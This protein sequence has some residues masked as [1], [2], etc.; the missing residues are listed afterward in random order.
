MPLY[1]FMTDDGQIV[2]QYMPAG[3]APD[4]GAVVTVTM[5]DKSIRLATRILSMPLVMGD[6]WKPYVSHR[7]PRNLKDV[8][9]TPS[10]KPIV[11]NKRQEREIMAR[12][13]YERE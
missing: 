8:P 4:V 9:C 6:T 12:F 13:G 5:P 10:G 11:Q 3:M 7:L 2:E 1:E